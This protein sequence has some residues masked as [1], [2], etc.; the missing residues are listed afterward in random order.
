MCDHTPPIR[1]RCESRRRRL[2][3][4][5]QNNAA[6]EFTK[7]ARADDVKHGTCGEA[8]KEDNRQDFN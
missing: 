2:A 1:I 6:Y 7:K 5:L 4:A 8:V 3:R